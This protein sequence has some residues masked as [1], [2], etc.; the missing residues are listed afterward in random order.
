MPTPRGRPAT[1]GLALTNGL[2][3]G[4]EEDFAWALRALGDSG[5]EIFRPELSGLE[6]VRA[7]GWDVLCHEAAAGMAPHLG[8]I[9]RSPTSFLKY[10]QSISADAYAGAVAVGEAFAESVDAAMGAGD[11]LVTPCAPFPLPRFDDPQL[12]AKTPRIG[13]MFC[14]LASAAIRRW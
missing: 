13:E 9:R 3:P 2:D 14:R 8:A 4:V 7:A 11:A 10:G 12:A 6:D 1:L 5:A